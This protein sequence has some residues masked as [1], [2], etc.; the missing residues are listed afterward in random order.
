M[1]RLEE[2]LPKVAMTFAPGAVTAPKEQR[3]EH[4]HSRRDESRASAKQRMDYRMAGLLASTVDIEAARRGEGFEQR[5]IAG[6]SSH[7][8]PRGR[9]GGLGGVNGMTFAST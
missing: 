7:P 2:R 5:L 6:C 4:R 9:R 1:K 8:A 3:A